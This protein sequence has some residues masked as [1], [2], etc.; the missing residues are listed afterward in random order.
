[1]S[2]GKADKDMSVAA[3]ATK[4]A[5]VEEEPAMSVAKAAKESDMST[6][7]KA[8]KVDGA[9]MPFGGAKSAKA[10]S[11]GKAGKD[12]SM[13]DAKAEK[14]TVTTKSLSMLAKSE[15]ELSVRY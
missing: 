10:M 13:K 7:A 4:V 14:E 5:K 15:K 2:V 6:E 12:L 11:V 8:Q 9:S 1:M 3:K